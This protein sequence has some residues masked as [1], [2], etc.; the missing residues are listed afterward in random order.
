[1]TGTLS[2]TNALTITSAIA[3]NAPFIMVR[4]RLTRQSL[5]LAPWQVPVTRTIQKLILRQES[6][7]D[8]VCVTALVS[9]SSD[10]CSNRPSMEEF[11]R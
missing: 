2:L 3:W 7:L 5:F 10:S 1:M 6:V 9:I 8:G 4:R 11:A